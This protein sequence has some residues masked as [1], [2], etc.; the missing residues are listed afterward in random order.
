MDCSMPGFPVWIFSK[1]KYNNNLLDRGEFSLSD[2][3]CWLIWVVVAEDW[4]DCENFL[5]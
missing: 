4:S 5:K 2:D 1:T 3:G